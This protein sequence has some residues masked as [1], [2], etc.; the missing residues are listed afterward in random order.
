MGPQQAVGALRNRKNGRSDWIRTSDPHNP[1]VVLY[2]AEPRSDR[3]RGGIYALT[4]EKINSFF[5]EMWSLLRY[6]MF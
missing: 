4:V 2:Q 5:S 1:I 3:L 6:V